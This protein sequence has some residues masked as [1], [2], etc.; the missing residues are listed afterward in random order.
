MLAKFKDNFEKE[1]ETVRLKMISDTKKECNEIK[2]KS[3]QEL[4]ET[5][6][7]IKTIQVEKYKLE[8]QILSLEKQVVDL[9][10]QIEMES[11]GFYKPKYDFASSLAYKAQLTSLINEQKN[12]VKNKTAVSYS[13]NWT[14]NGSIAE[15]RKM[16][17]NNIKQILRSFNNECEA[18]INKVKYNNLKI[19]EKRILKA[20]EQLNKLNESNGVSISPKYLDLKTQEMFLAYE[21]ENKKQNEKEELREQREKEREEKALQREIDSQKKIIDKDIKHYKNIINELKEKILN[22]E[23]QSEINDV[24]D[25]INE[26]VA[27]VSEKQSEKEELDYRNAHASAGY[28]YIIS[29]IGAFGKDVVKIGVTRRLEP[30]D[31]INELSSASVPFKYDVHALVFSYDAYKLEK[32]LHDYFGKYRVNKVNNRKE[33][34]KVSITEIEEKLKDYKELT[35]DFTSQPEA[36]EY[37]QTMSL[38]SKN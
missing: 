26:L 29:N 23:N 17:N 13:D 37:R 7:R 22:L 16:T 4:Q 15:G 28:V 32:E 21:Y 30:L 36:D 27:K 25:Q 11:F 38:S 5:V 20:Y 18:A 3:S 2:E 35:I 24:N 9:K 19:I 6:N 1:N 8:V 31:R 14:V 33:F 34:F 10:D 12:M